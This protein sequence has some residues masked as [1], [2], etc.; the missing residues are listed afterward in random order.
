MTAQG[1]FKTGREPAKL[2][3]TITIGYKKRGLGE[4]VLT[5]NGLKHFVTEPGFKRAY[6]GRI[7]GKLPVC[8]SINLINWNFHQH[9]Q[10]LIGLP[11][12]L[13]LISQKFYHFNSCDHLHR[14]EQ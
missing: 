2:I 4:I 5:G 11:A 12:V 8:K 13:P 14:A 7:T 3:T 6:R 10:S 9:F 1:H